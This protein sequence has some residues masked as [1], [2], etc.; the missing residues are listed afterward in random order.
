MSEF[1]VSYL[2]LWVV[3]LVLGQQVLRSFQESKRT[4]QSP[5]AALGGTDLGL[6]YGAPIPVT[7]FRALDDSTLS[8]LRQD[9]GR[10]VLV[11]LSTTCPA[12]RTLSPSLSTIMVQHNDVAFLIL[13]A[14]ERSELREFVERTGIPERVVIPTTIPEMRDVLGLR[15]YPF[16]YVI[17][18]DGRVAAKA[19]VANEEHFAQLLGRS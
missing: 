17:A 19:L 13:L 16:A 9:G 7:D 14:G 1:M 10:S 12:C 15:Y 3:V 6:D 18:H 2:I 11:F 5:V 8:L 4:A